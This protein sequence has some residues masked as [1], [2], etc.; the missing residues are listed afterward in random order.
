MSYREVYCQQPVRVQHGMESEGGDQDVSQVLLTWSAA[1][2]LL[3]QGACDGWR[4]YRHISL[5]LYTPPR[6]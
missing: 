6:I 2:G 1:L 3:N 4:K 5:V